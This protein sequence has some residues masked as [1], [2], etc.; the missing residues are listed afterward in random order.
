MYLKYSLKGF[1]KNE[2]SWGKQTVMVYIIS[3]LYSGSKVASQ[4]MN[5]YG[6]KEGQGEYQLEDH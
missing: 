4:I 2:I 1:R 5:K 3:N 6:W